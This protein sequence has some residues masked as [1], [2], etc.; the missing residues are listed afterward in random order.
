MNCVEV[1]RTAF[2]K[3]WVGA[4]GASIDPLSGLATQDRKRMN[5]KTDLGFRRLADGENVAV[6]C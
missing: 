5:F 6:I 1:W 3:W 2:A 4:K